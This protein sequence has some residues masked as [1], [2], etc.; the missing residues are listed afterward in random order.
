MKAENEKRG[1]RARP[2]PRWKVSKMANGQQVLVR[3]NHVRTCYA[4][5]RTRIAFWS[6]AVLNTQV[7]VLPELVVE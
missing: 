6:S 5:R 7:A 3:L 1:P 2:G 4:L